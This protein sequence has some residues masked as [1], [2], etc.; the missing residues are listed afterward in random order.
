LASKGNVAAM[1]LRADNWF[2]EVVVH[3]ALVEVEDEAPAQ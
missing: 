2:G 3:P 1:R